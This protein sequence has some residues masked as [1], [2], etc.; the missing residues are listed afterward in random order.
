M[1][2]SMTA[3]AR[4]E[5][6]DESGS[7]S[8]ELR[9]LNHRH[10]EISPRLPEELRVIE[11]EL[12][13]R[14]SRRLGRGKVDCTLRF[15]PQAGAGSGDISLNQAYADQLVKLHRAL[16]DALD[17]NASAA[18]VTD[19]LRWPG[20][21]QEVEPDLTPV[22]EKALALLD[23][24]LDEL[25]QSRERE[26]GQLATMLTERLDKLE[27]ELEAV[28]LLLPELRRN[29]RERLAE[30][31]AAVA[32]Q[33]DGNRLEQE[34]VLFAQKMDVDE[35]LDRAL[36][37]LVEMR[38]VLDMDEPVGRRLDFMLQELNREANTLGSKAVDAR[39]SRASVEIKV[40]IEQMREQVQNIE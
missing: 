31:L 25:V 10:L 11:P 5:A 33:V 15:K 21:V 38:R 22:Q 36:A 1:I 12:R 30:R 29:H 4:C 13:A 3:F 14:V 39:M 2:R 17:A 27:Q 7:L 23:L 18:Q 26:G 16:Q 8:W 40:L 28:R 37:H 24:A 19:L 35:E 20:V 34:L 32:E 6:L 9:A